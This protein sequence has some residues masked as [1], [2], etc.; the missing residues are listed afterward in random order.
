M[1]P[2]TCD[3]RCCRRLCRFELRRLLLQAGL[4]FGSLPLR[5]L[6]LLLQLNRPFP[7]TEGHIISRF[8]CQ[9]SRQMSA[10]R[11]TALLEITILL[12][13]ANTWS[14]QPTCCPPAGPARWHGWPAAQQPPPA[15]APAAPAAPPPQ[16]PHC[17][18]KLQSC[19]NRGAQYLGLE[20]ETWSSRRHRRQ[21]RRRFAR[22]PPW[23]AP[24]PTWQR[25]C[26]AAPLRRSWPSAVPGWPPAVQHSLPPV[27][28]REP[29]APPPP[30][31]PVRA[32]WL[33]WWPAAQLPQTPGGTAPAQL[34]SA[35][36]PSWRGSAPAAARSGCCSIRKGEDGRG[37][38]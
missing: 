34:R 17:S 8:I 36:Q 19:R 3:A 10:W 35:W 15:P 32:A 29:G 5:R 27:Q 37:A 13:A 25:W 30:A 4:R 28:Q 6:H 7:A 12:Q 23:Q 16:S 33:R 20:Q 24:A 31:Q 14:H 18:S 26:L 1:P 11:P 2:R 9:I 38:G 21:H 22:T